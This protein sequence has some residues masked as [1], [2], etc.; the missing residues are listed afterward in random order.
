MVVFNTGLRHWVCFSTLCKVKIRG[1]IEVML[2][3]SNVELKPRELVIFLVQ[4]HT[5][6]GRAVFFFKI[7]STNSKVHWNAQDVGRSASWFL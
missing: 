2:I 7:K 4:N 1:H 3:F 6:N 5:V